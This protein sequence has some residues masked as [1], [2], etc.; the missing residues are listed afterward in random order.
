MSP[1]TN[2]IEIE[3]FIH[4]IGSN[5]TVRCP[6]SDTSAR[7][8]AYASITFGGCVRY[9][10][11]S[12]K[13]SWHNLWCHLSSLASITATPSSPAF[14]LVHWRRC[15][16]YKTRLL[17]WCLIL[18]GGHTSVLHY[19][20]CTG[21]RWFIVSPSRSQHSCTKFYTNAVHRTLSTYSNLQRNSGTVFLSQ[22]E[23]LTITQHSDKHSSCICSI[24]LF[25][26]NCLRSLY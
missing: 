9:E 26:R 20:S 15:N 3:I 12:V 11:I 16:E 13:Q 25:P 21:C 19:N 17:Y 8:P 5:W 10:I 4:P 1:W 6:C 24:V 7:L 2:F 23:T 22:L 14:L 18:I